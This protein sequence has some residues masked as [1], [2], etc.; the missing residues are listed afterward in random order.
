MNHQAALGMERVQRLHPLTPLLTGFKAITAMVAVISVQGAFRLGLQGF[1]GTIVV[2][3]C[4]AVAFSVVSWLVTGY[5][6]VGRE[7]RI[8]EGLLVRRSRAIPLERLQAVEV[9][10]PLLARILGLAEL[11]LEV[12]GGGKTEAPLAYLTV[13]DA[14]SLRQRLLALARGSGAAVAPPQPDSALTAGITPDQAPA[15]VSTD[16]VTTAPSPAERHLHTVVNRDVLVSQVLTPQVVVLPLAIVTVV[17]QYWFGGTWG[18]VAMVSMLVA[19]I[20][21]VQQ[22]ARRVLAD[23]NFRLSVAETGLRV[24][25][26]LTELRSQTVPVHRIQAVVVVWPLLWRGMR[27]LR[28]RLHVAGYG[29]AQVDTAD[30]LLPVG[31]LATG[32]RLVAEVLGGVDLTA[33]PLRPAPARA[34]WIA[35]LSGPILAASLDDRV[36]AVRDRRITREIV[37]VPYSRIQSVRLVQGPLQRLFGL[38]TVHTDA[39]GG[40]TATARHRDLAEARELAA[41]LTERARIAREAD[42]AASPSDGDA[43]TPS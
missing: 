22:P 14:V 35:P 37:L 8:H 12:V 6:V 9:V 33:L 15:D 25:H 26:G 5:Q 43:A 40:L 4:L 19:I 31:D 18:F 16:D 17:S 38:A 36:F 2:T 41:E 34:R 21:V 3:M 32:R 11:R 28:C 39:A 10:R 24:R 20:G 29:L 27:W 30:R 13:A 23:W 1:I 7:L 42:R